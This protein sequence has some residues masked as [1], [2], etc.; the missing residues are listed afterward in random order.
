[1]IIRQFN[2]NAI[3]RSSNIQSWLNQFPSANRAD[4]IDLLLNLRFIDFNGYSE[5]IKSSLN[6]YFGQPCALYSIRKFDDD[7][8]IKSLWDDKGNYITRPSTTLGSEDFI[9]SIIS[10]FIKGNS[11]CFFD[12]PSL[13]MLKEKQI[14]NIVLI[15][16]SIG[17]GNRVIKFVKLMMASKTIM[18]WWSYGVINIHIHSIIRNIDSDKK[19]IKSIPGSNHYKRKKA[20]QSKIIFNSLFEFS[21]KKNNEHWGPNTE[22]IIELCKTT[23]SI[24]KKYRMGY[25]KT[26][27]NTIFYHSI[28][29]NIPGILWYS[30]NYWN[31]LFPQRSTPE[32]LSPLL[33]EK[34][35]YK[36]IYNFST[37]I[38][39]LLIDLL[40]LI[41]RRFNRI[42]SLSIKLGINKEE[43]TKLIKN[44][45]SSGFIDESL[46][47][48]DAGIDLLIKQTKSNKTNIYNRSIYIPQKWCTD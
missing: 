3:N 20:K 4:A 8:P 2:V 44:T 16:D 6:S 5:W 33:H 9:C 17:S 32:W 35:T 25:G 45:I 26:M 43:L 11:E 19:I 28:P 37:T 18:S 21:S 31:A 38:S 29:N 48:T 15:D 22:A 10:N 23:V 7:N 30:N 39:A 24:P 41:K 42:D 46:K 34:P 13:S 40:F 36:K 12:H 1:M 14:H 27:A 47:L